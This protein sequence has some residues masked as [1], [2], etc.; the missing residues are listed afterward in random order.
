MSIVQ[1]R[2]KEGFKTLKDT[3]GYSNVF[4][5]PRL[6]KVVVSTG[7]GKIKDKNK[8]QTIQDK[9][10]LITG[11]KVAPRGAKKSIASF[12]VREGDIVGYQVTLRGKRMYDFLDKVIHI[13]LPR[14]RDFR[15]LKPTAIDEM[16]N[17]TLGIKENTIFPETTD[18]D[19]R[20]VFGIAIT[21]VSTAKDKKEA[22]AF[23]R[24]LGFPLQND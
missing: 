16:G 9:L 21:V 23:Y 18:E 14:T 6:I 7:I 5:S 2:Q 3:F 12:K 20:D 17:M 24:H 13:A 11:Q 1:E 10:A 15:G 8:I 19:L 22:E 4:Q